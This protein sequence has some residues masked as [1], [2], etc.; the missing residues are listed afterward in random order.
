M[1]EGTIQNYFS[2]TVS[3]NISSI[4]L[5]YLNSF[6]NLIPFREGYQM[7]ETGPDI[8][9]INYHEVKNPIKLEWNMKKECQY[10]PIGRK[11]CL[12]FL[13]RRLKNS[14]GR[15]RILVILASESDNESFRQK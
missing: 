12:E 13:P 8:Y 6:K 2:E 14:Q 5:T 3:A 1:N 9:S 10:L 7:N 15:S 4:S 11:D